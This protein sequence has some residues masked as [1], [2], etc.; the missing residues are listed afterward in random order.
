MDPVVTYAHSNE[1]DTIRDY[2]VTEI[3][4]G[5]TMR[6]RVRVGADG[7]DWLKTVEHRPL[8]AAQMV[9]GVRQLVTVEVGKGILDKAAAAVHEHLEDE[10]APGA[11]AFNA[12]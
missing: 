10:P 1:E 8:Q 5:A 6:C 3:Y 9:D 11:R 12:G 7:K 2:D 4:D